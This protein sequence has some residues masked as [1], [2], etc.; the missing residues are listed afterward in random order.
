MTEV[1]PC[2]WE[3]T[4]SNV[5]VIERGRRANF[6]NPDRVPFRKV[7]VDGCLINDGL[8]CDWIITKIGTGSVFV[9]LKGRDVAHAFE[10]LIITLRHTSC[11]A[12]VEEKKCFLVVCSKY[13]SF[14]T[15]IAQRQ[16]QARKLGVRFKV[17]C[18]RADTKIEAL[19]G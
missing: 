14:D 5:T 2:V 4:H 18:D 9:E 19:L 12:W 16:E 17:I 1:A 7:K 11:N 6:Q 3:V 10:Q 13:P 8:R 15:V